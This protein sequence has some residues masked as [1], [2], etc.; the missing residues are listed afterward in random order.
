L[1]GPKGRDHWEDLNS[2][3]SGYGP[4]ASFCE[5]CNEPSSSLKKAGYFLK[6]WVTFS[7]PNNIL[8]HGVFK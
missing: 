1:V 8:H 3:S 5:Y 4:V 7:F 6:R 2:A